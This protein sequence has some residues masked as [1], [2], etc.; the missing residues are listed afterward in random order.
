MLVIEFFPDPQGGDII[1]SVSKEYIFFF[2]GGT[3]F[4][5]LCGPSYN[6]KKTF[7]RHHFSAYSFSFFC[8]LSR[9][10]SV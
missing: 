3:N 5:F 7:L 10:S 9:V 4:Y 1:I 8:F 6:L 2:K